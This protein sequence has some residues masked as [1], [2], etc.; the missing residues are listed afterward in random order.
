MKEKTHY[1]IL[2]AVLV[3]GVASAVAVTP[4]TVSAQDDTEAG[5]VCEPGPTD[6]DV[7]QAGMEVIDPTVTKDE[8]AVVGGRFRVSGAS[9]CS[10]RVFI[11]LSAPNEMYIQSGQ[12]IETGSIGTASGDFIARPGNV[13][14][15]RAR[16]F[17]TDIG[18]K[19]VVADIEYWPVGHKDMVQ[20]GSYTLQIDVEEPN[21]GSRAS[22]SSSTEDTDGDNTQDSDSTSGR[23]NDDEPPISF[24]LSGL[25]GIALI[26]LIGIGYK[27]TDAEIVNKFIKR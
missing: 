12:N 23:D 2:V 7:R 3:I 10:I 13:K 26:G 27:N 14:S 24:V 6:P 9:D 8:G 22:N 17:G 11:T 15:V 25:V 5:D 19:E 16:L 4:A 21:D 18:Q 1:S 20:T